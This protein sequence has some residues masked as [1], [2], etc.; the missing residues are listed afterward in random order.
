M[1]QLQ[2]HIDWDGWYAKII[3]ETKRSQE[4]FVKHFEKKYVEFAR[5][6]QEGY[7][8]SPMPKGKFVGQK[9]LAPKATISQHGGK[10]KCNFHSILHLRLRCNTLN[11]QHVCPVTIGTTNVLV[12]S[13]ELFGNKFN[14][15]SGRRL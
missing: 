6:A 4:L 10:M 3:E 9:L 2:R 13:N 8:V 1:F 12:P 7:E 14:I 11:D 15:G 5:R